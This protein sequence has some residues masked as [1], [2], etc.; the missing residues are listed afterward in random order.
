MLHFDLIGNVKQLAEAAELYPAVVARP[1]S[2]SLWDLHLLLLSGAS[3]CLCALG[4]AD[5]PLHMHRT[6]GTPRKPREYTDS[7]LI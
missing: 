1:Q 3:V 4:P 7:P 6:G 2:S 5:A